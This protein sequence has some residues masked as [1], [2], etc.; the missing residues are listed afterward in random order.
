M[1][2]VERFFKSWQQALRRGNLSRA[3][4]YEKK[5]EAARD[6]HSRSPEDVVLAIYDKIGIKLQGEPQD[7][8]PRYSMPFHPQISPQIQKM[9]KGARRE[10][11]KR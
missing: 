4:F 10:T 2:E 11:R 7:F 6:F 1:T 3:M 8:N 9:L 5:Y